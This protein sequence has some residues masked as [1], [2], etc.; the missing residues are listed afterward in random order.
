MLKN[1]LEPGRQQMTIFRMCIACWIRKA[2]ITHSE[3]AIIAAFPLQY[4]LHERTLVLR[5][6]YVASH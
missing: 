4:W 6:T 1:I 5:Y 3:Y 2:T